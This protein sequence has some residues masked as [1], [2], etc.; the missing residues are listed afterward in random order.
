MTVTISP[1]AEKY[2]RKLNKLDQIAISEKIKN[3]KEIKFIR[4][5]K[6]QGFKNIFRVRVGHYRI[7]Y[8]RLKENIYIILIGHRKDIYQILKYLLKPS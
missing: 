4:E 1:K 6:L 8:R 5:E 2:F 7:V 3:L